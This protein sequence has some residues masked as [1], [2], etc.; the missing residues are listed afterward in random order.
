MNGL[1][2]LSVVGN[3]LEQDFRQLDMAIIIEEAADVVGLAV[4]NVVV[5]GLPA[6]MRILNEISL[7]RYGMAFRLFDVK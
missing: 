3:P 2:E 7:M 6:Q 4:S 1:H 5:L